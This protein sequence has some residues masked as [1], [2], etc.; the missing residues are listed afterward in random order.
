MATVI[1]ESGIQMEIAQV[2]YDFVRDESAKGTRWSADDIFQMLGSLVEEFAPRNRDLLEK[3][4]E[5]QSK[6]DEYYTKKRGAGWTPNAASADQDARDLA[7]FLVEVG[8]LSPEGQIDFRMTVPQLDPDMDQNGP[9][10]VTPVTNA[11]MAVGGANAR[12]GSLY[13]AYF[14]S[15]IRPEIDRDS[16]RTQRL[17]MVV[18]DT[19]AFLD[20]YVA[21]WEEGAVFG[22]ITGYSLSPNSQGNQDLV[23]HTSDGKQIGLREPN[24]FLGYN[25]D[26][27]GQLSE[28]FLEDNGLKIQFLLYEGGK[29]NEENGQ[30]KDLIVESAITNIVDFED[31]VAIVDADDMVLALRNY[32]GLI[33][34]DLQGYGSRGN[35]KAINSDLPY[36]DTAGNQKRLKATSLMSVRNVSLHMYTD[37]V[38]V[39]GAEIPER[40]LGVFLTTLIA[41]S[42]DKGSNGENADPGGTALPVR[43]PNS[44]RGY[45]YQVAPKLQTAEE[46]AEQ[47]RLFQAIESKLGIPEGTILI[48]IMNEELGMT[49]QLQEALKASQSRTFFTNTGFLDRTGSQIRVQMQA[50][51]VDLR[52][53]LTQGIFNTSYERHNVDVSVR[54]GLHKRGKIGKGMQVRNRAMAEMLEKKI[55]HPRTGGNTAWV[56]A[57]YPS[58][59]HSMHY[60]MVDVDEV[61]RSIEDTPPANISRQSLLTFP[62][63]DPNK[64]QAPETAQEQLLRYAHSMLAYVEPWVHRGIGCSGV[65][66]FDHIEEMK[67]RATERIDGAI[68]A[69]WLLHGVVSRR[70]IEE[71]LKKAAEVVDEQNASQPDYAP[72]MDTP[73]KR[74]NVLTNP[75]VAA[76]LQI[77]DE[78][79]ASPSA[80]V[81]PPLFKNRKMVKAS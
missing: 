9:E 68:I 47:V 80:Y 71:S 15:D 12:W 69:N 35:L 62:M 38:T 48:G 70:D 76:V 57:P 31:A 1:L 28:F 11:S 56:P 39:G 19:N 37:M 16:Q 36:T 25:L 74:D 50:G 61:Q 55:D 33:R 29:V 58:D 45:V 6:I 10:L 64:L 41:C 14:L 27:Q 60:H 34:G 24:K 54:A 59:I 65:P 66:N 5:F 42:H 22:D 8:Y 52:D 78:A 72:M 81:E 43:G 23:G 26:E 67:D 44:R 13:D 73:E 51:P 30:F 21:G 18:E 2:M 49:L 40:I 17:R 32:L 7:E 46:V 77:V 63:L 75:A 53:D 20:N 4:S 3:R 79:L